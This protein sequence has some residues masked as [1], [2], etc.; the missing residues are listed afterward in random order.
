MREALRLLML[1]AIK[2][3]IC[4]AKLRR[5]R[6]WTSHSFHSRSAD[7]KLQGCN[8]TVLCDIWYEIT[9]PKKLPE[10]TRSTTPPDTAFLKEQD[11]QGRA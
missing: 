3:K 5:M 2:R 8:A 11:L 1:P 9:C 6:K 7:A 10:E 4:K